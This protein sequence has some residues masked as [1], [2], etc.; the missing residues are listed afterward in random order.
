VIAEATLHIVVEIFT[1]DAG[2]P[3]VVM[4]RGK[5][6]GGY[7]ELFR[8]HTIYPLEAEE[9]SAIPRTNTNKR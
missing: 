5:K 4:V 2:E 9:G 3:F 7:K 8:A 6:T 1:G